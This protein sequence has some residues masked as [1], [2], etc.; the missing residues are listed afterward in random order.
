MGD[1]AIGYAKPPKAGRF[2]KGV[3][4]NPKG[5]PRGSRNLATDLAAELREKITIREDGEQR[6]VSKQR[7]WVKSL[8][9]RALQGDVRASM[10]L[11]A[12]YGRLMTDAPAD[13]TNEIDA[14]E[15]EVLRRFAPRLLKSVSEK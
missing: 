13:Q 11:L 8:M 1:Y 15:L 6:R 2:K 4:G 12:I 14:Q 7:G 5:R 3:S 10:A 9:A